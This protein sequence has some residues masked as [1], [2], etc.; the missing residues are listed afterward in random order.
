MLVG[1]LVGV[2][3]ELDLTD[4]FPEWKLIICRGLTVL[5]SADRNLIAAGHHAC[6]SGATPTAAEL[7]CGSSR[8]V[9]GH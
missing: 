8:L 9:T 1:Y 5:I 7:G 2:K 3:N 6:C 4:T